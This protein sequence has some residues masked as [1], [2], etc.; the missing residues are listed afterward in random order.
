MDTSL[1]LLPLLKNF[2]LIR[3]LIFAVPPALVMR[4]VPDAQRLAPRLYQV[5]DLIQQQRQIVLSCP[6]KLDTVPHQT[7]FH[8]ML[9]PEAYRR[10]QVP[11]LTALH[12]EGFTHL[13]GR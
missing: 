7:L 1:R 3:D 11:D 8:R 12:D 2:P 10:K 13:R 6:S 4:L 5:R 9:N